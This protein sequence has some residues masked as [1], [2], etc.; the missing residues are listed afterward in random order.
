MSSSSSFQLAGDHEH[1]ALLL[2]RHPYPAVMHLA[3]PFV[4]FLLPIIALPILAL[5][6]FV[7]PHRQSIE[8]PLSVLALSAY[9]LTLLSILFVR[10]I[11][12]VLDVWIVTNER[13]VNVKQRGFFSRVVAEHKLIRV[14]DV[15]SEVHGTVATLLK[16][17]NVIVQT[18][19]EQ[20][21]FTFEQVPDP[22]GVVR[23]IFRLHDEAMRKE[24]TPA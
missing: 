17:G 5:A 22:E 16:F 15:T 13:I 8:Y 2:R 10:W 14:Q 23:T 20:G 24:K 21:K 7:L 1:I 9:L 12:Y 19:G 18:A 6:G 11:D 3:L 4:L